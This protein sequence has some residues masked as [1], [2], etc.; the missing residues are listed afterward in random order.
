MA[1]LPLMLVS[2][3]ISLSKHNAVKNDS[4]KK[5]KGRPIAQKGCLIF[6]TLPVNS[7]FGHLS[8]AARS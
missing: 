2:R 4:R 7:Y 5:L 6:A 1:S 8:L 3:T